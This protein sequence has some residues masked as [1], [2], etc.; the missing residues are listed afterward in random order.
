MST[1]PQPPRPPF[2]EYTSAR[3]PARR[4][5]GSG[6]LAVTAG[7]RTVISPDWPLWR[8]RQ[9]VSLARCVAAVHQTP[10]ALALTHEAAALVHGLWLARPEPDVHL[11]TPRNPH[12]RSRI[13]PAV[14]YRRG[15]PPEATAAQPGPRLRRHQMDL[16]EAD[17]EFVSDLP[18]TTVLR[19]AVDCAFDLPARESVLVVDSALRVLAAPDRFDPQGSA[20]R[21]RDV[22]QRFLAAVDAQGSRRGAVRARAVAA[23]ATAYSESPGESVLRLLVIAEGLPAPQVQYEVRLGLGQRYLDLSWPELGICLEFDGRGKYERTGD[24]WDEKNRQDALSG[25]GWRFLRV[26]WADLS[27]ADAVVRRIKDLFPAEV[28]RL[29]RPVRGLWE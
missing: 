12:R 5:R 27:D 26:T 6:T 14:V 7:V 9:A 20:A 28:R 22:R 3:R 18:V 8:Q 15:R 29:A 2:I 23:I 16:Q 4:S 10:S 11:A 1:L 13:L 25:A 24:V 17:I 19:T 21:W